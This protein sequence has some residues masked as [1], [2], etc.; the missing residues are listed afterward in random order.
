M[1]ASL[2]SQGAPE[3]LVAIFEALQF[4]GAS[5]GRLRELKGMEWDDLLGWCD[6]RQLTLVLPSLCGEALPNEVRHRI[7]QCQSR[8]IERF[9]RIKSQL[10]EITEA[11]DT[12]GIEF[13]VLK[14]LTHAPAFTPNPLLR[15]Q[16]DIDLWV[17]GDAVHQAREI[18]IKIGY[19]SG[20]RARSR[21][22]PPMRRPSGWRWRGD[23]FDPEMPVSIELHFEL[24]S[25]RTERIAVP[26]LNGFWSRR[27]A[28]TFGG[29]SVNV[30]RD[31]DL[32]GFAALHLLLH[33]L[34]GEL[35]AQRAWEIA[36]FLHN[37][38]GDEIFWAS[39]RRLH[40][41]ALKELEILV[42][43]LVRIWFSCDLSR[44]VVE[45]TNALPERVRAWLNTFSLSPLTRQ[46]RPNKDELWLHLALISP[47]D[48]V[49]ILTR[50]LF[51]VQLPQSRFL[52]NRAAHHLYTFLPTL[53]QGA[54][55]FC[56]R[57]R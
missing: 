43:Q 12:A 19:V 53:F 30:L 26:G 31:E 45:E 29:H 16:G 56:F 4:R 34:H 37:R 13:I 11:L 1:T 25:E 7:E 33:V 24:W 2:A 3:Y 17:P 52:L 14:G 36:S 50:R 28:R 44:A 49:R 27:A 15:A 21:H 10:F 48:R 39:W 9:S 51:P 18:L 6:A 54:R 23:R 8:Y 22:L 20:E 46:F 35:P 42:F 40:S 5:I 38:A 32:L 47:A 55:W 57:T 41:S